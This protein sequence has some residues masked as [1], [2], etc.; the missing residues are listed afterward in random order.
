M[1][2]QENIVLNVAHHIQRV[3][4]ALKQLALCVER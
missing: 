4:A 3:K 2:I 1:V